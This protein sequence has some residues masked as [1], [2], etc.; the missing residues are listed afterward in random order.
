LHEANLVKN[1]R[2]YLFFSRYQ[3][4]I[5]VITTLGMVYGFLCGRAI[6]SLSMFLFGINAIW[7]TPLSVFFKQK[8]WLWGL[9]WTAMYLLSYFWST[10]LPY[11]EE[12]VQVKIPF[13][14][15]PL[16]FSCLPNI[17]LKLLRKMSIGIAILLVGGC[18]YSL[19]Y[20][21]ID[22]QKILDGYSVSKVIPTPAYGDHI[23]FSIFVA[24]FVIWSFFIFRKM[25][26]S[27]EKAITLITIFIFIAYLHILAARS[28]LLVLYTF[29][30]LYLI[31]LFLKKR[32]VLSISILVSICIGVV[33]AYQI[34]PTLRS[35]VGYV[36]YSYSEY[37]NGNINAN[38]SDIGRIISYNLASKIIKEHPII[39]VG[40]GDVRLEMK[41]KYEQF[42]PNTKPE[43]RI[44]PH[45][46]ILEVTMVG[47]ITTLTLFLIWL[48]YPL[49]Q[50]KRNRSG[51]YVF[52]IWFCL[53]V[54]MLVEPMLEVQF[55]VFVYLFCFLWMQKAAE[56]ESTIIS[57]DNVVA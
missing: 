49:T 7:K 14:F 37:K 38:Y 56:S 11:W 50:I 23:R 22:T 36:K 26:S 35:K 34:F 24:W 53:F 30:F 8:W 52:A 42:S 51:F 41:N 25:I 5:A 17:P 16:A 55:G 44:V 9:A 39:G 19:S 47:G 10:D 57:P 21:V 32:F 3:A 33:A 54:S 48:F 40:A 12:R 20:F 13:L 18:V 46:Q 29:A 1:N 28:G 27:F 31:Y 45:N 6:L 43:Q 2:L 4:E 15:I